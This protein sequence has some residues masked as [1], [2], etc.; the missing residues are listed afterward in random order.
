[1]RSSTLTNCSC[2]HLSTAVCH[3]VGG[4]GQSGFWAFGPFFFR[5]FWSFRE[6][7]YFE[8]FFASQTLTNCSCSHLS[9]VV[10]QVVGGF[11]AVW[12][13][14]IWARFFFRFLWSF[15][16][17]SYFETF[18]ASFCSD[19]E[20]FIHSFSVCLKISAKFLPFCNATSWIFTQEI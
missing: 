10:C 9:T 13:L 19:F 2:S 7:S 18:F 15:R 20:K 1:M 3:V 12:V 14:G 6:F 5:F 4:F 11:G 16:E 17:F 8:I